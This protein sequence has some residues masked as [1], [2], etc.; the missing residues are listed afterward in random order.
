MKI[1]IGSDHA[2]FTLK[3]LLKEKLISWGHEVND[4]GT[5]DMNPVDFPIYGQKVAESVACGS[6]E[7]GIVVCGNGLGMS[8]TANKVPGI[9]A[10]LVNTILL[11]EESRK[12]GNANVLALGGRV[13]TGGIPANLAVDILQKW[14][15][16]DFE[17]GRHQ[18]RLAEISA[19][20]SKY[21][22]S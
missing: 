12:H 2:G 18:A 5:H 9:R 11:A 17:G 16:T 22:K 19:I 10:A 21:S 14:L 7:R 4:L 13:E 20:E 8:Y 3:E 15:S 6:S 1:S